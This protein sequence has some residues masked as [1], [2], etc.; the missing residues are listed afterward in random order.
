[1]SKI[2]RSADLAHSDLWTLDTGHWHWTLDKDFA[3]LGHSRIMVRMIPA[4]RI[5][6]ALIVAAWPALVLAQAAPAP[7]TVNPAPQGSTWIAIVL[8][9][10]LAVCVLIASIMSSRRTHRD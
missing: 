5:L 1:V 2:I 6:A 3:C 8:A 4:G 7:P 10:F 9:V